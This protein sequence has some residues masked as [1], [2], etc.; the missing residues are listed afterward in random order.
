[1]LDRSAR[2]PVWP[3]LVSRLFISWGGNRRVHWRIWAASARIGSAARRDAELA[4]ARFLA[5][6]IE[7]SSTLRTVF[8]ND[9]Y[10]LQFDENIKEQVSQTVGALRK[11]RTIQCF[12]RRFAGWYPSGA[13]LFS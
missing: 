11:G 9:S 7:T 6:D 3:L 12:T 5:V 8:T 13:S 10:R 1:M 4:Y 2:P